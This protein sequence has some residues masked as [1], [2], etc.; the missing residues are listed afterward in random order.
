MTPMTPITHLSENDK[1]RCWE[2]VEIK[3]KD[4][5][6]NWNAYIDPIWNYGVFGLNRKI[7]KAHRVAWFLKNGIIPENMLVCH[8][9]DNRC[10]CN[11]DHLFLGTHSDNTQDSVRKKR[12]GDRKGKKNGRAKLTG[13]RVRDIKM[14]LKKQDSIASIARCFCLGETTVRHIRDGDTWTHVA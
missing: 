9:C 1:K 3:S 7:V 12:W 2:K 6:W 8:H 10:C 14:R 4:G 13:N 11:P 5:C